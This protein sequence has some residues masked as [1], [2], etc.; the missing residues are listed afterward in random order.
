MGIA[1][2]STY[3]KNNDGYGFCELEDIFISDAEAGEPICQYAEFE[4]F[5]EIKEG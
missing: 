5:D 4:E 3:C 1:C 2:D